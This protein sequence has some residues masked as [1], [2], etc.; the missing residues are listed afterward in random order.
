[1]K[2]ESFDWNFPIFIHDGSYYYL[3]ARGGFS[4][5]SERAEFLP[6]RTL[7]VSQVACIVLCH[8]AGAAGALTS[9]RYNP[10]LTL[11]LALAAV[12]GQLRQPSLVR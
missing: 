4:G 5:G 1:M 11:S 12:V 6:L 8:C 3:E 9:A 10:A 7:S 2:E